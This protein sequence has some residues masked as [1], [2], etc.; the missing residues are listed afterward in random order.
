MLVSAGHL[1]DRKAF[2]SPGE[3]SDD[4][5]SAVSATQAAVWT[6]VQTRI[7][8]ALPAGW[9]LARH[10]DRF[11][12][13]GPARVADRARVEFWFAPEELTP[14]QEHA[15]RRQAPEST[16]PAVV[17][18]GPTQLGFAHFSVNSTAETEWHRAVATLTTTLDG[19]PELRRERSPL[20]VRIVDAH[21]G[22]PI[23][24]LILRAVRWHDSRDKSTEETVTTDRDGVAVFRRLR[25]IFYRVF[26]TSGKPMAWIPTDF[27]ADVAQE[28]LEI[29]LKRASELVLRAVDASTG[30]AIAGVEFGRERAL[31][32]FWLE[33][34][35]RE[36]IRVEGTKSTGPQ[37]R[38]TNTDGEFR[39]L[40]DSATWS[41]SVTKFPNG[42]DRI[43]PIN[44]RHEIE[45]PTPAGERVEYTFRL[46]RSS[47]PMPK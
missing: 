33:D 16:F 12:L 17:R 44:G 40:V 41:Y 8:A 24:G 22:T 47:S 45:I 1:S 18:F 4:P 21:D 46:V 42:Y 31:A 32:E 30:Q 26:L 19:I 25:P 13:N 37:D 36:T 15:R 20:R 14:A 28:E 2:G 34:I 29:R 7:Q 10:E 38:V 3:Q 9:S 6:V 39:C 23:A 11:V 35:Q 43:V 27:G 5:V